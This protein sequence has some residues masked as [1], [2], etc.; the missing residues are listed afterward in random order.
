MKYAVLGLLLAS[1]LFGCIGP[2]EQPSE[3]GESIGELDEIES[4]L[5]DD[6]LEDIG[7]SEIIVDEELVDGISGDVSELDDIL[8]SLDS[9]EDELSAIEEF[10]EFNASELS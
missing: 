2:G 3:V 5:D 4:G 1:L 7:G 6:E 9:L 8:G 10:P